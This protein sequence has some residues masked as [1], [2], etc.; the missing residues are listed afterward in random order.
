MMLASKCETVKLT[1]IQPHPQAQYFY[2][3]LA[4]DKDLS[5]KVHL[6]TKDAFKI[7]L[8]IHPIIVTKHGNFWHCISGFRQVV[9]GRILG[10]D[11]V[12]VGI[13]TKQLTTDEIESYRFADIFL[14][15]LAYSL[16]TLTLV[17]LLNGFDDT[18]KNKYLPDISTNRS[19]QSTLFGICLSTLDKLLG[20]S[21][22]N[23]KSVNKGGP[24]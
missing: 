6:F 20:K 3:C 21:G 4:A 11:E 24:E 17:K 18:I 15:P 13:I 22:R 7:L 23:N 14:N 19:R 1:S 8:D 16:D 12:T 2:D 5:A 10:I 9:I